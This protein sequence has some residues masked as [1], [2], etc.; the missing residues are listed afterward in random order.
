[1]ERRT[2]GDRDPARFGELLLVLLVSAPG[3]PRE[4]RTEFREF[5]HAAERRRVPCAVETERVRA[6]LLRGEGAQGRERLARGLEP[7]GV[8]RDT[9]LCRLV[10]PLL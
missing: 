3:D 7:E 1:M 4:E 10:P 6:A 8:G 2:E 5:L 9:G